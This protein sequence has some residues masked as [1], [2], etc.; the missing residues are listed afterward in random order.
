MTQTLANRLDISPTDIRR[1]ARF[2]VVSGIFVGCSVIG[3]DHSLTAFLPAESITFLPM[4]ASLCGLL[5][6]IVV[7]IALMRT[8]GEL[9]DEA[10]LERVRLTNKALAESE[11]RFRGLFETSPDAIIYRHLDA[12]GEVKFVDANDAYLT[13]FGYSRSDIKPTLASGQRMS[14]EAR[15][16]WKEEYAPAL[17]RDGFVDDMILNGIRT[18]GSHFPAI[19]R[20]RTIT[21]SHGQTVG[22]WTT[23]RDMSAQEKAERAL[24]TSEEKFRRLFET[25][26]LGLI[27]W[28]ID[29][30]GK[31]ELDAVNKSALAIYKMDQKTAWDAIANMRH[32]TPESSESW[33]RD[34]LASLK[35]NGF[36]KDQ[37]LV[38]VR[39]DGSHFP[40][41][42][43]TWYV[44]DEQGNVTGMWGALRDVSE[45]QRI[46]QDLRLKNRALEQSSV[47]IS[48]LDRSN[49]EH[50]MSYS[51]PAY[52][53]MTGYSAQDLTGQIP[54]KFADET[55][56]DRK[57]LAKV[58]A[59]MDRGVP[60]QARLWAYKKDGTRHLRDL[61]NSP[62]KDENGSITH[63]IS[64]SRDV[65]QEVEDETQLK[66][67]KRAVE[68][69]SNSIAILEQ[70]DNGAKAYYLNPAFKEM[71][72]YDIRGIKAQREDFHTIPEGKPDFRKQFDASFATGTAVHGQLWAKKSDG[73][74]QLRDIE[75]SPVRDETGKITH[76][77]SISRDVTQEVEDQ[78]RLK[79]FERAVD[80]ASSAIA[81]IERSGEGFVGTYLNPAFEKATGYSLED[82]KHR[83]PETLIATTQE[84]QSSFER[85]RTTIKDGTSFQ[86][87][88]RTN[89]K[90]GTQFLRDLQN[91]PVRNSAGEITHWV[92]V[93]RDV[94]QE[95]E[96]EKQLRL[97]KRT[98]EQS[99]A[100]I[101]VS[102]VRADGSPI[103][104]FNNEAAR[105][106]YGLE[107]EGTVGQ[108]ASTFVTSGLIDKGLDQRLRESRERGEALDT[109]GNFRRA[110]GTQGWLSIR[111]SPVR[112]ADDAITH[113]I[114]YGSD[115]TEQHDAEQQ[116]RVLERALEVS[117]TAVS[118]IEQLPDNVMKTTYINPAFERM[119]GYATE[120]VVGYP[121]SPISMGPSQN[122]DSIFARNAQDSL[123]HTDK[124]VRA[125]GSVYMREYRSAAVQNENGETTHYLTLSNDITKR[126]EAE[127]R[128]S[129]LQMVFEQSDSAIS[130][131]DVAGGGTQVAFAN[132][133][134]EQMTG[135]N[136][137]D[138]IGQ[139]PE[140]IKN[141]DFAKND[142]M[143]TW[144][145]TIQDGTPV[146]VTVETQR[147]SGDWFVREVNI[148]PVRDSNGEILSWV[149]I[150]RDV[151]QKRMDDQRLQR[152]EQVFEQSDSAIVITDLIN[153]KKT[154]A[155]VNP[156]F[157][158]MTG[159]T[160]AELIGKPPGFIKQR[161]IDNVDA[162]GS[163]NAAIATG[164]AM[165]LT[166][167]TQRKDGI[168]C[169]FEIES[170]PIRDSN[171]EI[172]S[173]VSF[174]RDVTQKRKDERNLQTLK[175]AFEQADSAITVME[176]TE[177]GNQ[178][179]FVNG[180]YEK[181]MGYSR[182]EVI[183]TTAGFVKN[184]AFLD[185]QAM[186]TWKESIQQGRSSALT[187][188]TQ[189]KDGSWFARDLE[190]NPVRDSEG[191][192][193]S[194][195]GV[196]RDI[197]Q[198]RANDQR[199]RTLQ[200]AFEQADNAISVMETTETG[201]RIVFV[202]RA[203]EDMFGFTRDEAIGTTVGFIKNRDF[204]EP[205]AMEK[206][207]ES[208][209][210]GRS[211][212]L[213]LETQRKNGS[214]FI[215]NMDASPVRDS[216]GAITSWISVSRDVT[217]K[218]K[219]E[220]RLKRDSI[221]L[222]TLGEAVIYT[223][224]DGIVIECNASALD[225]YQITEDAFIG[226]PI[227]DFFLEKADF[228]RDFASRRAR[229]MEGKNSS[230]QITMLRL[231]GSEALIE[232][233]SAPVT[234]TEGSYLGQVTVSRDVTEKRAMEEQLQHAQKMEAVGQLTGG[235]A[236]DFNNLM[237]VISGSL[238]LIEAE[239]EDWGFVH[240][241]A[242]T[243]D[244][245]VMRGRDLVDRML[246]FSRRQ[247]LDP[248]ETDIAELMEGTVDLL[249]RS[250]G[251]NISVTLEFDEG[252]AR[253]V[254]DQA[255]L[256]SAIL[257]ISLNAR[258]AMEPG[259]HLSIAARNASKIESEDGQTTERHYICVSIQDDGTGM[260][261]GTLAKIYE[262]FFTT[263]DIGEGSGLGL[264]MVY[265]FVK[266]SGGYIDVESA[267]G[268][269]TTFSLFFPM[270]T[271]ESDANVKIEAQTQEKNTT[272][273]LGRILVVE[274]NPDMLEITQH[275]L[276]RMGYD[277]VTATSASS[278]MSQLSDNP[279]VK[280]AFIDI[281]LPDGMTGTE[282]AK[283]LLSVRTDLRVLFTSGYSDPEIL[284]D[285]MEISQ[286]IRKP[287]NLGELKD[288]LAGLMEGP[289][290]TLH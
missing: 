92:G 114:S 171:G 17:K 73:T 98:M 280:I 141:R 122:R 109:M 117:P 38:G 8:L 120:D 195:I 44:R 152:L 30:D 132:P 246:S 227:M 261:E 5:L 80:Q 19:A 119:T 54:V 224:P 57:A 72:G 184:R 154:I 133:M 150:S 50:F 201:S 123:E 200:M 180:A 13:L 271:N 24:K 216:E 60:T 83:V 22:T 104:V 234:S 105:S 173:W 23:L 3:L 233:D 194:W 135:Y 232:F 275:S 64:V 198:K 82:F 183:G 62:V 90:D 218:L 116:R 139:R 14:E 89:K 118:I 106:M 288:A 75:N 34:C 175:M 208:I 27:A 87:R 46:E 170:G 211:V 125:D 15:Q 160:R 192:I 31:A 48:I 37:E 225:M 206:W 142:A 26:Q 253:C 290:T 178:V 97:F 126:V 284:K 102:Q 241:M 144:R 166:M 181:M 93:S 207:K 161:D 36:G 68:Q 43:D 108:H 56:E 110:D 42:V 255:Q 147:K 146:T 32:I 129:K 157:E 63:W 257:N 33:N 138:L 262:P 153:D 186:E 59:D 286:V 111:Y 214:W 251:D 176:M 55:D 250:I 49:P 213:T 254:I 203:Y 155:F 172:F 256:E 222:E 231:D 47:A 281:M 21:D 107:P 249:R 163:W 289:K 51:N 94:T 273:K 226:K 103:V 215:R 4:A 35:Q 100:A 91:S 162:M 74:A 238:Q 248:V 65:T 212:S 193:I 210:Q 158:A 52:E 61:Q 77:I 113:W 167:E 220:Q 247:N 260:D 169:P 70:T 236:H 283:L 28:S 79:L 148:A 88:V 217:Q 252:L 121:F 269:G 137:E 240:K 196:S 18:D 76:W 189:R 29:A 130:I 279:D 182:E 159:Y 156:A 78:T 112:D 179:A 259:G 2:I 134:F 53:K 204:L 263:K 151:T 282:L 199:L 190:T 245:S 86:G 143:K 25:C 99:P 276:G 188:E 1:R 45:S 177:T 174:G 7:S 244:K 101:T 124:R 131:M 96:D 202:N 140:I 187:I 272:K 191:T 95:V 66:L 229:A 223:N 219:D 277:V 11:E 265:G 274:D 239:D 20:A 264:S 268:E 221:I 270:V 168:W 237:G 285:A 165:T 185:L 164:K 6:M 197:T 145:T 67:F 16:R 266:Q 41:L 69:A 228:I 40:M 287:F 9:T 39:P 128:M 205:R 10:L 127:Q 149:G 278:A 267:P 235:I 258:D 81:I 136:R 230:G 85:F 71:S 115:I 12:S 242:R 243:A 209:Q 58:I 84:E